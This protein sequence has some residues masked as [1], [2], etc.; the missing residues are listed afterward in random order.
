MRFG[1]QSMIDFSFK[2]EWKKYEEYDFIALIFQAQIDKRTLREL[3]SS[4]FIRGGRVSKHIH[5][6]TERR[7]E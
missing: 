3:F 6:R 5:C 7:V 1:V 2:N 4:L